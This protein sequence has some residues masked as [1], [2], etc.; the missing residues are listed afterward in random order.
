MLYKF[1]LGHNS[2]ETT[3]KFIVW[4]MKEQKSA[5]QQV[6]GSR[7]FAQV[8][9]SSMIK[10]GTERHKTMNYK[11]ILQEMEA[12][13]V[14]LASHHSPFWFFSFTILAKSSKVAELNKILQISH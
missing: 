1:E 9:W 10:Q 3:K 4:K 2:T 14:S 5:V 6:D 7:N 12:Y 13:H 8:T 11:A